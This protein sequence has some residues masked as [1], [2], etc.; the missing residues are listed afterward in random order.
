M[1]L[2]KLFKFTGAILFN[3]FLITII[4]DGYLVSAVILYTLQDK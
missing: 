1:W 2:E 4:Y 3:Y